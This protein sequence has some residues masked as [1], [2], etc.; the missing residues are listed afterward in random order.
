MPRYIDF[1]LAAGGTIRMEVDEPAPSAATRRAGAAEAVAAAQQTLEAAL[2]KLKPTAQAI[3][4]VLSQIGPQEIEVEFG[5]K[6]STDAGVIIAKAGTEANFKV[7]LKWK[8]G[9]AETK[10]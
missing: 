4:G 3:V 2:Q 7:C 8:S 5:F 9:E 10:K 6:A 1:P